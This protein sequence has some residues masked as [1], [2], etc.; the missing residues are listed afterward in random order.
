MKSHL[1]GHPPFII[2][3]LTCLFRLTCFASLN[4]FSEDLTILHLAS[5]WI[6]D[7]LYLLVLKQKNVLCL[8]AFMS[9]KAAIISCWFTTRP[10]NNRLT[11]CVA[12]FSAV[13]SRIK[14]NEQVGFWWIPHIIM[15]TSFLCSPFCLLKP[16]LNHRKSWHHSASESSYCFP[17]NLEDFYW[18]FFQNQ[19]CIKSFKNTK[20]NLILL[21]REFY[22]RKKNCYVFRVS[23]L[24]GLSQ[25]C[26]LTFIL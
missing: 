16:T 4:I 12:G 10:Q 26:R 6:T 11:V 24:K 22:Y 1:R 15:F 17:L 18:F 21:A 8:K 9:F 3:M 20:Q 23:D 2:F 19:S 13:F 7:D 5:V 25:V 14:T